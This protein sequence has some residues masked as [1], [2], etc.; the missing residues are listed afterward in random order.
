LD[1]AVVQLVVERAE[2]LVGRLQLLLGD[3]ELLVARDDLLV[4][5]LELLV[6]RLVLLDDGLE[7]AARGG[8]LALEPLDRGGLVDGGALAAARSR[9]AAGGKV[10]ALEEDDEE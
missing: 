10:L 8:E 1:V 2:L 5:G 6:G 9:L 3:L 4:G 7:V